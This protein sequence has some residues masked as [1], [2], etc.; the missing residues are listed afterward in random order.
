MSRSVVGIYANAAAASWGPWRDR[1]S[2]VA[3]AALGE[4]IQR[5]GA[6]VV[7]LAPDP[8]L[9]QLELLHAIDALV[10][11]DGG[12][13]D[14]VAALRAAAT[15]AG[16]AVTVLDAGRTTPASSADDFARE[17]GGLL[18]GLVR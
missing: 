9:Q 12:D 14:H 8:A 18:A 16:V 5:A 6:I 15:E 7:L 11:L 1:P 10:V 3:P 13:A 4:A 17:L 2:A